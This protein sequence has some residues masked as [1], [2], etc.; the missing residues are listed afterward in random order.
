MNGFSNKLVKFAYEHLRDYGFSMKYRTLANKAIYYG[1]L[2]DSK[3][4]PIRM[5]NTLMNS[6]KKGEGIFKKVDRGSFVAITNT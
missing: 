6:I 1:L 2:S 3:N 5:Y 4:S